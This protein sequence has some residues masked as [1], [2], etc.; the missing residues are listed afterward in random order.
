VQAEEPNMVNIYILLVLFIIIINNIIV[1]G[2]RS[3]RGN[4]VSDALDREAIKVTIYYTT[5]H[6]F[7]KFDY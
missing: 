4:T 2:N 1:V 6:I 5:Q 3:S 7:M